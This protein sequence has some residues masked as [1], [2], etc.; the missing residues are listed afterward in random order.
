ME[1][2][3][4]IAQVDGKGNDAARLNITVDYNPETRDW[5]LVRI[6][7]FDCR[8]RAT[9]DLTHL[10]FDKFHDQAEAMI[11]SIDW[12]ELMP[13]KKYRSNWKSK[14]AAIHPVMAQALQPFIK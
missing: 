13:E 10:L 1:L 2:T 11:E 7:A 8:T 5:T 3:A 4:V 9:V 6:Q 14:G 12:H